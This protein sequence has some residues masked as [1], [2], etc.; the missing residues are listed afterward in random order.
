L[1]DSR[2]DVHL[3]V[4]PDKISKNRSHQ[5][6]HLQRCTLVP[7]I[8]PV[9][10][11]TVFELLL[12]EAG[13]MGNTLSLN[14]NFNFKRITLLSDAGNCPIPEMFEVLQVFWAVMFIRIF[15]V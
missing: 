5:A 12:S 13:G 10:H 14:K 3:A 15:Q 1:S 4:S 11:R 8:Q 6:L 2:Q 9:I 7:E